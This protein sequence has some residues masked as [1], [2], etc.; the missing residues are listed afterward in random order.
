MRRL[1]SASAKYTLSYHIREAPA[2][3]G[4]PSA[5]GKQGAG[6]LKDI[7]F[8]RGPRQQTQIIKAIRVTHDMLRRRQQLRQIDQRRYASGFMFGK[9]RT[10]FIPGKAKGALSGFIINHEQIVDFHQGARHL[11]RA[12]CPSPFSPAHQHPPPAV[13]R[14]VADGTEK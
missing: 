3:R 11:S 10:P 8:E 4:N 6:G 12:L 2:Y 13:G 1:E 9:K 5:N 14:G 7:G